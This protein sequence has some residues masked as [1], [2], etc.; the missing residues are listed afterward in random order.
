MCV[1]IWEGTGPRH[2]QLTHAQEIANFSAKTNSFL[3]D[4]WWLFA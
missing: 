4:R 2:S 1:Y 3:E